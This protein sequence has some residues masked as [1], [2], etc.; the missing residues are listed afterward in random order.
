MTKALLRGASKS[1]GRGGSTGRGT[2]RGRGAGRPGW[3]DKFFKKEDPGK[4][5][6]DKKEKTK[7]TTPLRRSTRTPAVQ[8]AN[9]AVIN[10]LQALFEEN[11][12]EPGLEHPDLSVCNLQELDDI[13]AEDMLSEGEEDVKEEDEEEEEEE[14]Q[15]E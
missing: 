9:P 8:K 6:E 2:Y 13:L 1:P 10:V 4:K 14:D 11:V 3:R 15:S 7:D 12:D 5:D